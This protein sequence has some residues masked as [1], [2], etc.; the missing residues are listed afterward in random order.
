VAQV[1][2]LPQ[3][4]RSPHVQPGRRVAFVVEVDFVFLDI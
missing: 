1:Q 2:P 4:H 3:A